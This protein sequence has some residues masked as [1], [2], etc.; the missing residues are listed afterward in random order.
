MAV[1][2]ALTAGEQTALAGPSTIKR[3][4]SYMPL[5]SVATADVASP[6]PTFPIAWLKVTSTSVN[7][8]TAIRP[9]MTFKVVDGTTGNVKG[10]YRVRYAPTDTAYLPVMEMSRGEGGLLNFDDRDHPIAA[11]DHI[12]IYERYDLWS[13][14][15]Y[16]NYQSNF[17]EDYFLLSEW[18]ATFTQ[19]LWN[20]NPPCVLNLGQHR[21]T[22]VDTGQ[23][24]ATLS[25][26]ASTILWLAGQSITTYAWTIPGSWTVT[27]GSSSTQSFT[28]R[29]PV[30]T[31]V[32]Y[33]RVR[34]N[35][36]QDSF[37]RRIVWVYDANTRPLGMMGT[38]M[39]DV[40]DRTGRKITIQLVDNDL[41]SIPDGAMVQYWEK[42]TWNGSDVPTATKGMVGWIV[43]NAWDVQLNTR[44][45]GIDI[46]GPAELL[47]SLGGYSFY[48]EE[49]VSPG[50]FYQVV[51]GLSDVNY[52]I[53]MLLKLRA[54][55]VLELFDHNPFN[56]R[57]AVAD[58]HHVTAHKVPAGSLLSQVQYLAAQMSCNYGHS[59]DGSAWVRRHPSLY[60]SA[61]RSSQTER[62][63]LTTT[64]YTAPVTPVRELRPNTRKVHGE[65]FK[66][67]G[68]V[69]V[70]LTAD[71]PGEAPG[72]GSTDE[73]LEGQ[74]VPA[75]GSTGTYLSG[76]AEIGFLTNHVYAMHNNPYPSLPVHIPYNRDVYEPAQMTWAR[77]H[78][79]ATDAPDGVA[80]NK[81]GCPQRVVKHH[82]PGLASIDLELEMETIGTSP[83]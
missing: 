33:C 50:T 69:D 34:N 32:L 14:L 44:Q 73:R 77:Y 43:R 51:Q 53:W 27:V 75:N 45:S 4:L 72:Q 11:G 8:L 61:E 6:S 68:G 60:A 40:R 35:G 7:W 42:C 22:D 48:L 67:S 65:A 81:R 15:P 21:S 29:V 71:A 38:G 30:G 39:T 28:A 82:V 70:A 74:V 5:T 36:G 25:F 59:S 10:W 20:S 16:I 49:S 58:K 80:W 76:D 79:D 52:L 47:R 9:G 62:D 78:L 66:Y 23:T 37:A 41:A 18:K 19:D 46:V 3:Y 54:P 12:T 57:T 56:S 83:I 13:S 55:N 64:R 1:D 17:Y 63:D 31:Y 2:P 26:T 24:Y